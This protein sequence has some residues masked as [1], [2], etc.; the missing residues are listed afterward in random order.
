MPF[1]LQDLYPNLVLFAA[2][3]LAILRLLDLFE[4]GRLPR[5]REG[6]NR[7]ND[8]AIGQL[9]GLAGRLVAEALITAEEA[10]EASNN[11]AAEKMHFVQYLV[12]QSNVDGW[13]LAEVASHEFG[14]PVLDIEALD[15]ER[16]PIGLV[17]PSLAKKH[18]ALPLFRRGNSLFIAL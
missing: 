3:T 7:M 9:S 2:Q 18:R 12:H 4:A 14:V 15:L 16:M 5:G 17:E 10:V 8:K 11:A 6:S 1:D 13:R